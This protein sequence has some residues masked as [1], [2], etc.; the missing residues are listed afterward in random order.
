MYLPKLKLVHSWICTF[1]SASDIIRVF[2]EGGFDDGAI[3][4]VFR[5]QGKIAPASGL[6]AA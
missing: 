4:W 2:E 5:P 1:D 6:L 3:E